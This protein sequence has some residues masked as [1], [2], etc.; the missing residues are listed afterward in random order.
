MS[1]LPE[2]LTAPTHYGAP[3]TLKALDK[4]VCQLL[5]TMPGPAIALRLKRS[6]ALSTVVD[7]VFL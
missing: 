4:T 6:S 2:E 5:A 3:Q 1:P 7:S